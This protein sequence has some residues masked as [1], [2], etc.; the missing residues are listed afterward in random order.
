MPR[1]L[2]KKKKSMT[3][4]VASQAELDDMVPSVR[5]GT[6]LSQ[7]FTNPEAACQVCETLPGRKG[8]GSWTR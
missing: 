6:S 8:A 4:T 3:L 2:K 1:L 5:P 7:G